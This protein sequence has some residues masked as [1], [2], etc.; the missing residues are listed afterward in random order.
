MWLTCPPACRSCLL[1]PLFQILSKLLSDQ[2][3]SGIVCQ[4]I[5]QHDTS[6]EMP[7]FPSSVKEAQQLVL[8]VLKDITDTLQSGHNVLLYAFFNSLILPPVLKY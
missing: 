1:Q 8:L 3:V 7:N 6:H 5:E 4:H 2:W